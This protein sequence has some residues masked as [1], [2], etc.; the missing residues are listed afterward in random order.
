MC[1]KRGW[2]MVGMTGSDMSESSD[3]SD[4]DGGEQAAAE[5]MAAAAEAGAA[6]AAEADDAA[7]Y[8]STESVY[9][10]EDA[11]GEELGTWTDVSEC[12]DDSDIDEGEHA[13][14]E[15]MAAAAETGAAAEG[16][17]L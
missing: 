3:E 9:R 2:E 14:S 4:L 5:A 1:K 7:D 11:N 13:V 12:S 10:R 8:D 15:A 16:G 17:L 6:A